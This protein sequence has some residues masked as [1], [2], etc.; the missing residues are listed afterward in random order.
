MGKRG[1]EDRRRDHRKTNTC[2]GTC[3]LRVERSSPADTVQEQDAGSMQRLGIGILYRFAAARQR[4]GFADGLASC[5]RYFTVQNCI[6][7]Y[8]YGE[9]V[10]SN[11]WLNGCINVRL[12]FLRGP[13]ERQAGE[14]SS[15]PPAR[16]DRSTLVF[17]QEDQEVCPRQVGNIPATCASSTGLA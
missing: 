2:V 15:T 14:I 9:F 10:G 5:R 16:R 3:R 8:C 6:I 12:G 13:R 7:R 11:S 4:L 17:F 1:F